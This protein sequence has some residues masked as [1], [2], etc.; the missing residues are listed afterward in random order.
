MMTSLRKMNTSMCTLV[1]LVWLA[2]LR[3]APPRWMAAPPRKPCSVTITQLQWPS[4]MMITQVKENCNVSDKKHT[5]LST[6]FDLSAEQME[7]K[8]WAFESGSVGRNY[9]VEC[10]A[11]NMLW[12]FLLYMDA[13]HIFSTHQSKKLQLDI[14]MYEE[15]EMSCSYWCS[16]HSKRTFFCESRKNMIML[17]LLF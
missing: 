10:I 3:W 4:M 13:R 12:F 6:T 2:T 8:N 5:A 17:L 16:S 9:Y 7:K 1:T 11:L 14:C 15:E